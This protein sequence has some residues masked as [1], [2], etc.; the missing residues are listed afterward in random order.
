MKKRRRRQS[1]NYWIHALASSLA[2]GSM[3]FYVIKFGFRLP[4]IRLISNLGSLG[5]L[6]AAEIGS[7][8]AMDK[9]LISRSLSALSG[10]G[11]VEIEPAQVGAPPRRWRLTKSGD[12]FVSKLQPIW[13][14]REGQAQGV[15]SPSERTQLVDMLERLFHAS[16]DMRAE[17]GRALARLRGGRR[18]AAAVKR[19]R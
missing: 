1:I 5:P 8:T 18:R 2:K 13:L 11:Y 7:V 16:E 14:R 15:L 19:H 4:E 17:E 6:S 10:R 3:R 12:G 9:G